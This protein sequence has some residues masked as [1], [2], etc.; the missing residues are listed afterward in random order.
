MTPLPPPP[1]R[2]PH[3]GTS[4][5]PS[6]RLLPDPQTIP[7]HLPRYSLSLPSHSGP[8]GVRG[9][10]GTPSPPSAAYSRA[11]LAHLRPGARPAAPAAPARTGHR[12]PPWPR[13]SRCARSRP[14]STGS[15][16]GLAFKGA[17]A[18]RP[19]HTRCRSGTDAGRAWPR[20]FPRSCSGITNRGSGVGAGSLPRPPPREAQAVP[21]PVS[22]STGSPVLRSR[23]RQTGSRHPVTGQLATR[24]APFRPSPPRDTGHMSG[25]DHLYSVSNAGQ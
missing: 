11:P 25:G 19:S 10:P 7:G 22:D 4:R 12:R 13:R 23:Y 15:A 5:A 3:L 8:S 2:A 1:P 14:C 17:R 21:V 18:A 16:A 24:P 9:R 20:P 6:S